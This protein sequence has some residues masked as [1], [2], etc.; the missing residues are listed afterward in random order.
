MS[1]L[2]TS[3]DGNV[4]DTYSTINNTLEQ[5]RDKHFPVRKIRFKRHQH[6]IQPWMTDII[7]LNIKNKDEMYVRFR[8]A[9]TPLEKSRL[10]SELKKM[11]KDI[12]EWIVEA[13]SSYFAKKFEDHINYVKKTWDTIKIAIDRRRHKSHFPE[14]F[15]EG[16]RNIF[17]M[18][19][20]ISPMSSINILLI[21]N[22]IQFS[23]F[24]YMGRKQ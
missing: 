23:V 4:E 1:S 6:K 14:F 21:F 10:K 22:S 15:R 5:L 12:T 16:D 2:N 13:K 24:M 17:E 20:L 8:K 9:K 3:P 7:L 18:K 19:K 11:E